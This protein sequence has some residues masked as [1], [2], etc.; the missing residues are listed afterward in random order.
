MLRSLVGSEMCIRDR[1]NTLINLLIDLTKYLSQAD[2]LLVALLDPYSPL[3][4]G[5]VRECWRSSEEVYKLSRNYFYDIH[6]KH[7]KA[8][9]AKTASQTQRENEDEDISP[10]IITFYEKI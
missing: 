7:E 2:L 3:V 10:L 5:D 6:N 4:P 1:I 8:I 9:E